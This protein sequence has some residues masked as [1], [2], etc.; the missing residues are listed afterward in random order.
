MVLTATPRITYPF[1][2]SSNDMKRQQSSGGIEPINVELDDIILRTFI[3]FVQ[4]ANS[5]RK[6]GDANFYGKTRLSKIKFIV[7]KVLEFNGGT[8]S[9]SEIARWTNT[10]RNNVTT[11]IR[12]LKQ[13][14]LVNIERKDIDKRFVNVTLTD[15]G[16]K[17][18]SQATPV[19][20]EIVDKVMLSIGERDAFL[21]EK[22]LR[23]LWKNAHCG[24]E[25]VTT[26]SQYQ[27]G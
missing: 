21:L 26:R 1:F 24:L 15:K 19:A 23:V 9:P 12:R 7:L 3:V 6:Y 11:L 8:M 25:S 2:V 14:G 20:R 13:D 17:A 18:I 4:T 27:S 22:S 5:V 10:E 16:R